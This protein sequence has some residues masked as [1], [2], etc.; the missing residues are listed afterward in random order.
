[1]KVGRR[2]RVATARRKG[3]KSKELPPKGGWKI[4]LRG[5]PGASSGLAQTVEYEWQ[6]EW[7][8]GEDEKEDTDYE[9]GYA[10]GTMVSEEYGE[11]AENFLWGF[12]DAIWDA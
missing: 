2:S 6:E 10:A 1:M 5:L 11:A 7:Q 8:E 12:E 3:A 9:A 4:E